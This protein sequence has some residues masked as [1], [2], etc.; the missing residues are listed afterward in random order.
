LC[1]HLSL[2]IVAAIGFLLHSI[3]REAGAEICTANVAASAKQCPAPPA[4]GKSKVVLDHYGVPHITGDSLYDV[5]YQT[6]IQDARQRRVQLEFFR[7][8]ATGT[9]AE[10]FG[11][12]QV[13]ADLDM[14][15]NLY[16]E[17][18]R[19]YF[20]STMPCDLQLAVQAYAEGIN[21]YTEKMY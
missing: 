1:R 9:L 19:A 12:S 10:V 8:A 13:D 18:E 21:H 2:V 16:T 7:R 11:F 6:G 4:H 3:A 5:Y 20:F 17:E 14:R 15:Q